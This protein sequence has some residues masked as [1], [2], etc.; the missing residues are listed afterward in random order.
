MGRS[1]DER[2]VGA[3]I[4]LRPELVVNT[5]LHLSGCHMPEDSLWRSAQTGDKGVAA[6]LQPKEDPCDCE[7][8]K[9]SRLTL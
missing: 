2:T 7:Q 6:K 3:F 9:G 1:Y 4:I 5:A 8:G